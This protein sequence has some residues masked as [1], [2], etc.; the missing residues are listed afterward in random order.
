MPKVTLLKRANL[1]KAWPNEA[2]DFTP[3]LAENINLLGEHLS[4]SLERPRTEVTLPRAGRVDIRA[5]Q[6]ETKASVVIEN[7]LGES[8]DSHCLRLLGYAAAA[9]ANILV[10][11]AAD[12]TRYHQRILKWLNE[13]DTIDVYAVRVRTY[14]AGDRLTADFRTVVRPPQQDPLPRRPTLGTLYARFYRPLVARL[15]G[16]NGV[17]PVRR[18]GGRGRYRSFQSGRSGA[19]YWTGFD[20][21][22][23]RVGLY[24]HGS[25]HQDRYAALVSHKEEIAEKVDGAV[26][27]RDRQHG[28]VLVRPEV[29]PV[30]EASEEEMDAGRRWME[31][32]L[33][34][35]RS[36][37]QPHLDA[38][39]RAGDADSGAVAKG[40]D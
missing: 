37:V 6:V 39:L 38:L 11:V 36:A 32:N 22:R 12:F 4:L 1:R 30:A 21:G 27:R 5:R 25:G 2:H 16:E 40:A 24:L 3:W 34:S 17:H 18:G 28:I 7:Q 14:R 33:L 13:A 8:D 26:S 35:L 19:T 10:W 20:D 23:P 9:E 15:S 29:L 31:D